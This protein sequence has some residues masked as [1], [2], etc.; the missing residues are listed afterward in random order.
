MTAQSTRLMEQDII[1]HSE[2]LI[3]NHTLYFSSLCAKNSRTETTCDLAH[4]VNSKYIASAE[5]IA[6]SGPRQGSKLKRL[7]M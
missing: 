1:L 2:I 5:C 7:P 4:T 6:V 3:S